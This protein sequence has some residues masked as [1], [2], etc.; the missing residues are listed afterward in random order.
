[1]DETTIDFSI[2]LT[3]STILLNFPIEILYRIFDLLDKNTYKNMTLV[4]RYFYDLIASEIKRKRDFTLR[5]FDQYIV[6]LLRSTQC[7]NYFYNQIELT[8]SIPCQ[9]FIDEL[10]TTLL[11]FVSYGLKMTKLVCI[12]IE[13]NFIYSEVLNDYVKNNLNISVIKHFG[14]FSTTYQISRHRDDYLP[15]YNILYFQKYVRFYPSTKVLAGLKSCNAVINLI[16]C[17]NGTY[18]DAFGVCIY[19][20]AD[21]LHTLIMENIDSSKRRIV[22][23]YKI[24][25][26]KKFKT[27]Q[28]KVKFILY[29]KLFNLCDCDLSS[30]DK[31]GVKFCYQRR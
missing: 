1:M 15:S 2:C 31:I 9:H 22:I 17:K 24:S 4:C 8:I 23:T 14:S 11:P 16:G 26:C 7:S 3:I 18:I 20:I 27:H 6:E 19:T 10:S 13:N 29:N 5:I 21:D 28:E 25:S 30:F 12:E